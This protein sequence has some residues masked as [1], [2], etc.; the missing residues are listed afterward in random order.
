MILTARRG[1]GATC[2]PLSSIV[3][4]ESRD[5]M[6]QV[7]DLLGNTHDVG[8]TDWELAL[9]AAPSVAFP[10]AP[11]TYLLEAYDDD[12][13]GV[14]VTSRATV[15]GWALDEEGSVRPIVVDPDFDYRQG[16]CVLQ[17]DGRVEKSNGVQ[18]ETL[19]DWQGFVAA[20]S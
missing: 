19:A 17:P 13:D 10:A 1:K 4:A 16:W 2:I 9:D 14:K 12:E 6:W 15:L 20:Q 7:T 5:N 8:R 3:R 11:G 18:W